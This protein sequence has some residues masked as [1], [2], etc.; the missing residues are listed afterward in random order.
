MKRSRSIG[1]KKVVKKI[2][3]LKKYYKK[4]KNIFEISEIIKLTDSLRTGIVSPLIYVFHCFII[5]TIRQHAGFE[6]I[7]SFF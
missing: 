6:N 1:N 2:W 5:E 3:Q 7:D 4:I